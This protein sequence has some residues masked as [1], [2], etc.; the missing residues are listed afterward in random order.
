MYFSKDHAHNKSY[1][2]CLKDGKIKAYGQHIDQLEKITD[3]SGVSQWKIKKRIVITIYNSTDYYTRIA[4]LN[5][6]EL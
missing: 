3:T 5:K 1:W 6:K 2:K 4:R